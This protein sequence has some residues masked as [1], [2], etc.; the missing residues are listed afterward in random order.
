MKRIGVLSVLLALCVGTGLFSQQSQGSELIGQVF[1]LYYPPDNSNFSGL[2]RD[3]QN[4]NLRTI[5]TLVR[6]LSDNP[7]LR[8]RVIGYAN[9]VL[10]TAK[11]ESQSLLPLSRQRAREAADILTFYGIP[12]WRLVV[13]GLGGKYP[14][15]PKWYGDEQ[16]RNRRVEFTIIR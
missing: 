1:V 14:L 15:A 5:E 9:A 13:S 3:L 7:S 2:G 16:Y 8:V 6:I 12:G 11:E 4:E 10:N